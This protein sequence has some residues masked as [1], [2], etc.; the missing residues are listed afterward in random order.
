V[1]GKNNIKID[2]REIRWGCYG[3]DLSFPGLGQ[4]QVKDSCEHGIEYSGSI[5]FG[6]ILE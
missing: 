1:G 2:L 5:K 3:L 4:G 6:E